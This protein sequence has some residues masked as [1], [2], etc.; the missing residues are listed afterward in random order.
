M[1]DKQKKTATKVVAE[2]KTATKTRTKKSPAKNKGE[3]PLTPDEI[4]VYRQL[5]CQK[6]SELVGDLGHMSEG[7]LEGGRQDSSGEL[8]SMPIH[9]ADVGTDNYE[10]EFTLGLIDSDRKMLTDIDRALGKVKNGTFG[11]C[12]STG[13]VIGRARL[14]AMPW[15]RYSVEFASKIEQGLAEPP[16]E[17]GPVEKAG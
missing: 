6:R 16:D 13:E 10:Q 5:L 14:E 9:M 3:K 2:E 12:E 4:E 15:A 17:N 8:S 1:P 7:A 11:I